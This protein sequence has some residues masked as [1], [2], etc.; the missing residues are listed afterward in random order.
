MLKV[1]L[2]LFGSIGFK[3]KPKNMSEDIIDPNFCFS[4]FK[5][6][7]LNLYNVDTFFHTWSTKYDSDLNEIYKPKDFLIEKQIDFKHDL[8]E[9]SMKYIDYYNEVE[10]LQFKKQSPKKY[11][12]NF[13]FR[14]KSRWHSQISS[15]E[16][17]SKYKNNK[18]IEYDFVIQSRFD[19]VMKNKLII[20]NLDK[21]KM[22]LLNAKTHQNN[23]L[24]DNLFISS[25]DNAI[26]FI[27]LKNKLNRYP[28]C[29][30]NLLPI[31]FKEEKITFKKI[32]N[33][34]EVPIHRYYLKYYKVDFLKKIK[35]F[36][37]GKILTFLTFSIKIL[38][39]VY[40]SVH[41]IIH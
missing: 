18:N 38:R 10:D 26:K 24:M 2:C 16:L 12:E 9:Y 31:F 27:K 11:Y 39:K 23:Q 25:F 17:L 14:T 35:I 41:K 37:I 33:E 6:N 40:I 15:L 34:K 22:N 21:D 32:L 8:D 7:I 4:F 20:D 29:P 28:I 36:F 13:I 3:Q 5:K 30:T 19:L 1:A